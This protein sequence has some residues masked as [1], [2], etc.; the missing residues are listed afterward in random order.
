MLQPFEVVTAKLLPTIRSRLAQVLLE[1]YH[2]RQV[3]VARHLGITQAAVSHY[4]TASRGID[5][6]LV[7]LF[8]EIDAYVRDMAGKIAD[9]APRTEQ[10][11]G[12]NNLVDRL[13]NTQRFCE[14]HKRI[15]ALDPGCNICFPMPPKP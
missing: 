7:K 14:Y 4:K 6:E 1:E 11:L 12:L 13:M 9:G 8:P 3:D 2:M 5:P 10:V 15:A